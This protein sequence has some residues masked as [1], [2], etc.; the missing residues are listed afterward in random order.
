LPSLRDA[1][2]ALNTLGR[3]AGSDPYHLQTVCEAVQELSY[4]LQAIESVVGALAKR[5]GLGAEEIE[6][7][8]PSSDPQN[9][10]REPAISG[11]IRSLLK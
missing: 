2:L 9:G 6:R 7:L 1:A 5:A 11:F 4:R 10:P 8:R 3:S